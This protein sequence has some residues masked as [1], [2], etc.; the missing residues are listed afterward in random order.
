M[1]AKTTAETPNFEIFELIDYNI[2]RPLLCCLIENRGY[3]GHGGCWHCL[4]QVTS[5][6]RMS[7]G[8]LFI[9]GHQPRY[10]LMRRT[11]QQ[12]YHILHQKSTLDVYMANTPRIY[13]SIS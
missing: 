10:R 13:F 1:D 6:T 12:Q 4:S 11:L 7:L 8:G 9:R 2:H 5:V 3:G